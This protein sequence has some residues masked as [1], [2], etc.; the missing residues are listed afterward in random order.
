MQWWLGL[1]CPNSSFLYFFS[2]PFNKDSFCIYLNS[3]FLWFHKKCWSRLL[4]YRVCFPF[5][6]PFAFVPRYFEDSLLYSTPAPL[7][8][9]T[10]L[11]DVKSKSSANIIKFLSHVLSNLGPSCIC[12]KQ[13]DRKGHKV[14]P[15]SW[16]SPGQESSWFPRAR[17]FCF[18]LRGQY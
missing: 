12:S 4:D 17:D 3:S 9:C 7:R 6:F 14:M 2:L 1:C 16:L 18:N 10:L 11:R 15:L 8:L 5:V 13:V